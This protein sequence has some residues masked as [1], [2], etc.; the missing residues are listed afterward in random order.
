MEHRFC[1]EMVRFLMA[2]CESAP[3]G[4]IPDRFDRIESFREVLRSILGLT[5]VHRL[6]QVLAE[7]WQIF[8][9]IKTGSTSNLAPAIGDE[10]LTE[11]QELAIVGWHDKLIIDWLRDLQFVIAAALF[12]VVH[13]DVPMRESS[14]PDL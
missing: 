7:G 9:A 13:R 8:T 6:T 1:V 10:W 2:W 3:E 4:C 5:G 12:C 14:P 11:M